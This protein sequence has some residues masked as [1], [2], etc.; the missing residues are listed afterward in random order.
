ME[1]ALLTISDPS[2]SHYWDAGWAKQYLRLP[3]YID[4]LCYRMQV[5]S[6]LCSQVQSMPNWWI[7]LKTVLISVRAWYER[8]TDGTREQR[9]SGNRQ[10]LQQ[11][12]DSEG[13]LP[14]SNGTTATN[15]NAPLADST[16]LPEEAH[17]DCSSAARETNSI[18]QH[19]SRQMHAHPE[20]EHVD[21]TSSTWLHDMESN[22]DSGWDVMLGHNFDMNCFGTGFWDANFH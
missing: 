10:G 3:L 8:K 16:I 12:R 17:I 11:N 21:L 13:T 5:V 2:H 15:S 14:D 20:R 19:A 22:I 18:D 6:D 1:V 9:L 7:T 4:S